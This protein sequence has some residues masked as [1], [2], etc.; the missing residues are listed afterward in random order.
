MME[1]AS[2]LTSCT[3]DFTCL[4]ICL[5]ARTLKGNRLEFVDVVKSHGYEKGHRSQTY[6][7]K[8][9]RCWRHGSAC[10]QDCTHFQLHTV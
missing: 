4:W 1:D 8:V 10:W 5:S 6:T 7:V 3:H 2:H 9:C